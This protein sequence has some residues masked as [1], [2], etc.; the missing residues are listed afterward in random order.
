MDS[1]W[2]QI[3]PAATAALA[4]GLAAPLG[5]SGFIAAFVAGFVFGALQRDTMGE[6]TYLL[7]QLGELTNGVTFIV[8][9]AVIVGPVL[10]DLSWRA[11]LYGVLSLTVVRMLP[12]AISLLGTR[13]P[14]R[15]V[16]RLVRSTRARVDRFH[17]HRPRGRR[18]ATRLD[19]HG[20]RGLHDRPFR[21]RPWTFGATV[22]GSLRKLVPG[23]PEG[24]PAHH[25]KRPCVSPPLAAPPL[26]C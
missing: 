6:A 7:D 4:Y 15:D 11:A 18:V 12:V 9:G 20:R 21:L 25:G 26:D 13:P 1:A 5:G 24:S 10:S 17:D 8:F 23:A 2:G 19:D 22:D 16:R 3:L 14:K